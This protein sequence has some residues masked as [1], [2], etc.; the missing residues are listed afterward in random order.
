MRFPKVR[1]ERSTSETSK[2]SAGI[3][4][5]DALLAANIGNILRVG[6]RHGDKVTGEIQEGVLTSYSADYVVLKTDQ[7]SML[8]PRLSITSEY[9]PKGFID[10]AETQ[11]NRRVLRI[12]TSGRAAK[13]SMVSLERGLT[14]SP[15]YAIDITNSDKLTIVAKATLIDDLDD[16]NHIDAR[17]VTGF[18]NVPYAT[19]LEPLVSGGTADEFDN[20]T[21]AVGAL[22]QRG[23]VQAGAGFGGQGGA[24][25]Q[26]ARNAAPAVAADFADA[27]NSSQM[28]SQQED[29]FFYKQPDVSV[30]KGDRLYQILFKAEAPFKELYTWDIAD[31]AENNVDYRGVIETQDVWHVLQFKN[32]SGQP[33]TTAI[34]TTFKN[35]E[36]LGQDLMPYVSA[37]GPAEVKITKA[38]DV[39][40]E[41]DEAEVSRERGAIKAQNGTPLFD[42]VTLKGTLRVTSN[43]PKPIKM[44]IKKDL[45]GEVIDTTGSPKVSKTAKG[46]RAVNPGGKIQW[47][48]DVDAGKSTTLTY[49]YKLYVRSQQ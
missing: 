9:W 29:L 36:I 42:L 24:G 2:S 30:K 5:L 23:T 22:Y 43:K 41:A 17:F 28:G 4:G 33:F 13:V 3:S 18:P 25:G 45:T 44:R 46:L 48:V 20:M 32:T 34:A 35:G 37:G 21:S 12:K 1:W 6:I 14:W 47:D 49:N 16:L 31:S 10:H 15:S 19:M 39:H 8:I 7:G 40:A 11:S 38:M 27:M 26:M